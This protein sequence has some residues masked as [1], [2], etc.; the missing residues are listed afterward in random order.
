MAQKCYDA[1]LARRR[2]APQRETDNLAGLRDRGTPSDQ[3]VEGKDATH[4][5]GIDIEVDLNW[6]DEAVCACT[7]GNQPG[8]P[9]AAD[10]ESARNVLEAAGIPCHVSV[11]EVDPPS[12]DLPRSEYCVMVPGALNLQATSVLDVEIFNS[13]DRSR[14]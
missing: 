10:A 14:L 3:P 5:L 9:S 2:V 12:A 1:E 4:R 13:K 8:S 11:R 7:F 6:L